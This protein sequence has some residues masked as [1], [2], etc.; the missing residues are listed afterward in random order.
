MTIEAS[1]SASTWAEFHH[2]AL[3]PDWE[4]FDWDGSARNGVIEPL[5]GGGAVVVTG[6]A[7]GEVPYEWAS[8]AER[9]TVEDGWD[10]VVEVV[11]AVESGDLRVEGWGGMG[12]ESENLASRGPGRYVVRCSARDRDAQWDQ[13]YE[14]PGEAFRFDV[15][16]A[17]EGD[18]EQVIRSS[19]FAERHR[20]A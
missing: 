13:V 12:G 16:P 5:P 18:E 7:M 6:V 14:A 1:G 4:T 9:P 17:A 19:G 10:D 3:S 8:H 2:F 15:W 11:L 20:S